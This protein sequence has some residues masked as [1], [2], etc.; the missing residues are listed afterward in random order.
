MNRRFRPALVLGLLLLPVAASLAGQGPTASAAESAAQSVADEEALP[1]TLEE[2]VAR[3]L[4][5]NEDILVERLGLEAATAAVEGAEGAYDPLL[6]LSGAWQR[7]TTPVNSAFSGAPEGEAAPTLESTAVT[8]GLSQLLSTGAEVSVRAREARSESNASFDL[9]SP[10]YDSQVGVEL[11]QPLL[12]NRAIDSARLGLR[13]AAADRDQA[14]AFLRLQVR[15]TV[16]AVERAYWDLLAA[17]RQVEVRRETVELAR[18]Q[19]SETEIR[20]ENGVAPEAEVAQPRAALES[21]RGDLLEAL[22]AVARAENALKVLI[23]GDGDGA[24]W[25][26][27]ITPLEEARLEEVDFVEVDLAKAFSEALASRAE[28][29]AAEALVERRA[30]ETL[31]ARDEVRPGLDLVLSYD[32]YGLAGS[33]NPRG[34]SLGGLPT[35]VPPGLAGSLDDSVEQLVDGDFDDTRVALLFQVPLG[36]RTARATARIAEATESQA[37]AELARVRKAV[38]AEV[39]DAVATLQAAEA[40]IEAARAAHEAAEVQLEAERDRYSVGLSTNFLVLTRQNELAEARLS[41]IEALTDYRTAR[42]ELG[43][44]TGALLRE[45]SIEID[46]D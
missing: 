4:E 16:A 46:R 23:L 26:R 1:L 34:G 25:T 9:L 40:R 33:R 7:S 2:A 39:L 38:R 29:E 14:S 8:A 35:D 32:R 27:P 24:L 15:E 28:V 17:R 20:I 44:A 11:R 45:R 43:R 21:R 18:E 13:V 36:R 42:T 31:F 22:E 3:A 10:A 37:E 5:R 30:A 12:R 41:E 6:S 19:L